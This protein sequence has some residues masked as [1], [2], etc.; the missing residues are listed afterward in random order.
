MRHLK[1]GRKLNRDTNARKALLFSLASSLFEKGSIKT[2]LGKAKFAQAHVETLI[3]KAKKS[4]LVAKRRLAPHLTHL[5]FI[6]LTGELGP[7][8]GQVPGG[9]TRII[10]LNPRLGDNAPMA[11]LELVKIESKTPKQ[12]TKPTTTKNEKSKT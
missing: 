3:T 8:F 6:K 2:T 9:Y 5:A 4:D 7:R 11:R 1:S 10:K 12:T